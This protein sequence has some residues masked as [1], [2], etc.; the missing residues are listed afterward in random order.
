M[1][2]GFIASIVGFDSEA[3]SDKNRKMFKEKFLSNP[4][5]SFEKIN[6]ASKACGPLVKWA[7]AQ[8]NYSD[9]LKRVDPLRQELKALMD[10]AKKNEQESQEMDQIIQELETKIEEY[11]RE[12]ADLIGQAE[13]IKNEMKSV[14][15]KVS[16]SEG[17]LANLG[18][19]QSRWQE[20]STG[21]RS[22]MSTL[23]GDCL[24]ASAFV[25][26][27]GYFD[28]EMRSSL[29][30]AWQERL[31]EAEIEFRK[32]LAQSEYLSTVDKRMEWQNN[33]LPVDELCIEN[34]IMLERYNRYPLIVD[35]SGQ[36]TGFILK[37]Y[38]DKKIVSTSFLDDAFRKQLESCLRFGNPI[39]VNDAESYDPILNPVLNREVRRSGGRVLITIGDQE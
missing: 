25:A 24:L 39:L 32:S 10:E 8:L 4:D 20:T 22:Q 5:Y 31:G 35:P 34:A 17:L 38:A 26:Y 27:A 3:I 2:D 9:M 12:Y 7:S 33:Q 1:K 18:S 28:Q 21:F 23:P 6:K 16:R 15:S 37:Q 36:A 14:E 13:S 30:S 11:K 29:F 19:E